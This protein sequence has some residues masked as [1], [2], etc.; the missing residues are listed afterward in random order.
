[1]GLIVML[2]RMIRTVSIRV[3]WMEYRSVHLSFPLCLLLC[4]SFSLP[5]PL[6]ATLLFPLPFPPHLP[7]LSLPLLPLPLLLFLLILMMVMVIMMLIIMTAHK[8]FRITITMMMIMDKMVME[9]MKWR[10]YR[11]GQTDW[12]NFIWKLCWFLGMN[13]YNKYRKN[14]NLFINH[15]VHLF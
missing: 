3:I 14:S 13:K 4:I 7:L 9:M 10:K 1:M 2:L 6:F 11:R 5:L 8:F 12:T 15:Q